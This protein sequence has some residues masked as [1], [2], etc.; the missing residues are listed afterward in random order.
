MT[1]T[2]II[3]TYNRPDCVRRCLACLMAQEPRPDQIIVVDASPDTRTRDVVAEF[4]GVEYLRNDSG[5]GHM[6]QSRNLGL[7]RAAGEVVA[8][9]DDDAFAHPDWAK[10]LLSC[11]TDPSVG[12]VGGRALNRQPGEEAIGADRIGRFTANGELTGFFAADPGQVIEVDHL[13]GCNMSFRRQVLHEL[14]GLRDDYPGTELREETDICFRVRK[15]GY[16]LLF[17]PYAIVDH[18]G[19]PQ[20]KGQRFDLRYA[21]YGQRNHLVLLLRNFGPLTPIVWRYLGRSLL[22]HGVLEFARR[23][24]AAFA[25]LGVLLAGTATGLAAGLWLALTQGTGSI[26]RGR[27]AEE[28]REQ[29]G[30]RG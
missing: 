1:L 27:E 2:V 3:P 29:M 18:I 10:N 11:Y 6:T 15:Q 20:G 17:T 23:I 21:Y 13:V 16:R 30:R 5:Y 25:R 19:A 8:F 12:G 9:L 28:L 14:G 26:R 24:A 7:T 4:E 22:V